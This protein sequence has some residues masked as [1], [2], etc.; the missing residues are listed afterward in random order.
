MEARAMWL[1]TLALA[2]LRLLRPPGLPL[3]SSRAPR[4]SSNRSQFINHSEKV[5]AGLQGALKA[6]EGLLQAL[7][8]P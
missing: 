4:Q 1:T 7:K 6:F 3:G 5:F 8:C 2:V